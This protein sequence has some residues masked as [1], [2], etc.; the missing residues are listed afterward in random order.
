LIILLAFVI[1]LVICEETFHGHQVL[2]VKVTSEEQVQELLSYES[3][4]KIDLWSD[5]F[6]IGALDIRIPSEFKATF[7]RDFLFRHQLE[8]S[9]V[10]YDLQD[11]INKEKEAMKNKIFFNY[12][13]GQKTADNQTAEFFDNYRTL[14]EIQNWMRQ[15]AENH[16]QI[17]S[18]ITD[19]GVKSHEGRDIIGLKIGKKPTNTKPAI[20]IHGGIHAREWISPTTVSW[21]AS[22]LLLK[23]NS[24]ATVKKLVDDIEWHI[25]PVLNVDGYAFTHTNSRMWRKTRKPNTGSSCVGTD[26]NRNWSFKWNTGGS[27][28]DPCSEIFHGRQPFDNVEVKGMA[29]YGVRLKPRLK[30]YIDYHAFGQLYMRPW[31]YTRDAPADE[32]RLQSIGDASAAAI[33]RVRG[34][35]Y[36][37]GRIAIIIYVASGSSADYFYGDHKINAFALELST[38]FILPPAEIKPCGAENFEGI[39]VFATRVI[40]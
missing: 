6:K 33:S 39:K 34:R 31:G 21:I 7:E 12:Q 26:P 19:F 25:F 17:C 11:L 29:D 27:S 14:A 5:N 10:V 4:Q 2:R 23:Y 30:G 18:L 16:P 37:S 22:E 24:D 38:S 40:A 3:K 15:M 32:S 1:S 28:S 35:T 36:R 13:E 8:S 20:L 9:I